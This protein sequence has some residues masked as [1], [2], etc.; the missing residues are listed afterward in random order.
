M[1]RILQA[2]STLFAASAYL[3]KR[4]RRRV[5]LG[6]VSIS[7]QMYW[8]GFDKR[9]DP[10][11]SKAAFAGLLVDTVVYQN[12][13]TLGYLASLISCGVCWYG[14]HKESSKEWLSKR[15]IGWHASLHLACFLASLFG[16]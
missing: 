9:I 1:S 15:H 16:S 3:Q 14:S 7:S 6:T 12:K 4:V 5:M 13:F 11:I 2:S 8:S 10:Y